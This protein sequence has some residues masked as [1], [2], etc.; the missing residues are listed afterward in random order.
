MKGRINI[1]AEAMVWLAMLAGITWATFH[2]SMLSI[3]I[4]IVMGFPGVLL[5]KTDNMLIKSKMYII[6]QNNRIS[7]SSIVSCSK[8]LAL[9]LLIYNIVGLYLIDAIAGY[10]ISYSLLL[11]ILATELLVALI[12]I[13]LEYIF[14]RAWPPLS[15]TFLICDDLNSANTR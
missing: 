4:L 11:L 8:K 13:I 9:L 14:L 7:A 6:K 10:N 12:V 2:D 15:L 3:T 1:V 5:L